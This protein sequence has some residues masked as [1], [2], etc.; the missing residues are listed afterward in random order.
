MMMIFLL[1]TSSSC[2]DKILRKKITDTCKA[3]PTKNT[4]KAPNEKRKCENMGWSM[5][6]CVPKE[7]NCNNKKAKAESKKTPSNVCCNSHKSLSNR[8]KKRKNK[9]D[10]LQENLL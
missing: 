5:F 10:I 8:K 6:R 9:E 3:K 1:S 2:H 7:W 4:Y